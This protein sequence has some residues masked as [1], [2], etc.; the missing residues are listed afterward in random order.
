MSDVLS[1]AQITELAQ[2]FERAKVLLAA[3]ELDLFTA[4]AD[5]PLDRDDLRKRIAIDERGARDFFDALVAL[6]LLRPVCWCAHHCGPASLGPS[7]HP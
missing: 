4:L 2:S 7:H 3:V 1:L 6:G 5:G